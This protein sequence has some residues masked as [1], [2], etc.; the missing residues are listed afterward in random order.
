MRKSETRQRH[1]SYVPFKS[2]VS[3]TPPGQFHFFFTFLVNSRGCGDIVMW[4]ALGAGIL[5]CEFPG[6]GTYLQWTPGVPRG[7]CG[8]PSIWMAHK[9]FVCFYSSVGM[10]SFFSQSHFFSP[11]LNYPL[12]N[13]CP[14]PHLSEIIS[15]PLTSRPPPYWSVKKDEPLSPY[16][17]ME[18]LQPIPFF[19][20]SEEGGCNETVY[21]YFWGHVKFGPRFKSSTQQNFDIWQKYQYFI[22]HRQ[23]DSD[24]IEKVVLELTI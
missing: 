14:P 3:H 1:D 17:D 4:N 16:L 5:K 21:L 23:K 24:V 7:G 19:A 22:F 2:M 6:V 9:G 10:W 15:P 12:R 11:P 20:T 8:R 18:I 13:F